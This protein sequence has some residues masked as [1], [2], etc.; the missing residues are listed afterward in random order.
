[1]LT[2]VFSP[3]LRNNVSAS[4]SDAAVDSR[5]SG[6]IKIPMGSVPPGP[7]LELDDYPL[8]AADDVPPTPTN[9]QL[10]NIAKPPATPPI[11]P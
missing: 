7:S 1:M 8:P 6:V 5:G 4:T 10:S 2:P 9:K 11:E 3:E